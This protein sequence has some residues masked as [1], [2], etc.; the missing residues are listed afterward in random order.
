MAVHLPPQFR[1]QAAA[2]AGLPARDSPTRH[3][4]FPRRATAIEMYAE[5]SGFD[6]SGLDYYRAFSW[7]KMACLIEGVAARLRAGAGGGLGASS[8][9]D[10]VNDRV[11]WMLACA[12]A[13]ADRL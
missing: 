10:E 9:L 8:N 12:H 3:P 6:L 7:W 13:A 2:G 11:D 1:F 5:R 4:A